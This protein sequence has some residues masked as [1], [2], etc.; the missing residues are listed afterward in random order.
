MFQIYQLLRVPGRAREHKEKTEC[1]YNLEMYERESLYAN[2]VHHKHPLLN[3]LFAHDL[4]FKPST[5]QPSL[6]QKPESPSD[7]WRRTD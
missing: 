6:L 4:I 3:E 7:S 2:H 5:L 1:L